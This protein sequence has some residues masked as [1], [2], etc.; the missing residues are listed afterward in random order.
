M[1]SIKRFFDNFTI[2]KAALILFVIGFVVY[3]NTLHN[4]FLWDDYNLIVDNTFIK[5]WHFFPHYFTQNLFAGANQ[6]DGY[7]RP[8][9]LLSY[10]IDYHIVGLDPF[11]YHFENILWHI[12][13]A[14]LVYLVFLKLFFNRTAA[15]ISALLF[16][17]HP[18]QIEAVTYVAGRSD[19][20]PAVFFLLSFFFFLKYANETM[21]KRELFLSLSFFTL[22]FFV[23]E[24]TIIFPLIITVY[25]FTLYRG[26]FLKS[27]KEKI[28]SLVPYFFLS[29]IYFFFRLT[30]LKF[31]DDLPHIG[32]QSFLEAVVH[33]TQMFFKLIAVFFGLFIYPSALSLTREIAQPTSFFDPVVLIGFALTTLS[34]IIIFI[35]LKRK[36]EAAFGILWFW[37]LFSLSAYTYFK[38]GF[39][40]EHWFYL[41]ILG[42]SLPLSLFIT[43]KITESEQKTLRIVSSSLVIAVLLALSL[44]TIIRNEDWGNP[45]SFYKKG[46][47]AGAH[48]TKSL[49]NLGVEYLRI[50]QTEDATEAFKKATQYEDA[51]FTPWVNLGLIYQELGKNDLAERNFLMA[52]EKNTRSLDVYDGLI[53]IYFSQ[54]RYDDAFLI[55]NQALHYY[56]NDSILLANLGSLYFERKDDVQALFFLEKASSLDPE[57]K[58]IRAFIEEIKSEKNK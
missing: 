2:P 11:L 50:G 8:L 36:K 32:N 37:I 55:A 9:Q 13:A 39:A 16:L 10:A 17:V 29:L 26:P 56:P 18:L 14:F 4:P 21:R 58:D 46:L 57:N 38:I 25:L 48:P 54:A 51:E 42:L 30:V 40:L 7:W 6:N 43:R 24:R 1:L 19:S 23:H 15:F 35:S 45:I 53:T 41:P 49:T 3:G 34:F 27:T 28:L 52:L 47:S 20:M 31:T 12:V 33:N 5:D 22:S 44:R